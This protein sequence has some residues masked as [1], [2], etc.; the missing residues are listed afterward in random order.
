MNLQ[1]QALIPAKKKI[2]EG[3]DEV[4]AFGILSIS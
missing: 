3:G 4:Q 2:P 1:K